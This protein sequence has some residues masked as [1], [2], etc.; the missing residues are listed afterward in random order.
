MFITYDNNSKKIQKNSHIPVFCDRYFEDD[1]K[2]CKKFYEDLNDEESCVKECPYGFSCVKTEKRI[3]TCLLIKSHINYNKVKKNLAAYNEKISDYTVYTELNIRQIID[4]IEKLSVLNDIYAQTVHDIKNANKSMMDLSEAIETNDEIQRILNLNPDL[5]SLVE[6]YG[7]IKYRLDYHDWVI[8][9]KN[10][11][12]SRC[13]SINVHKIITKLSYQLKYGAKK[14]NI[15][16]RKEGASY[17][18]LNQRVALF[19]GFFLLIENAIKYSPCDRE[20]IIKMRDIDINSTEVIIENQC[21]IIEKDEIPKLKQT[22]FRA[23]SAMSSVAGRGLGLK[24]ADNI[25]SDAKSQLDI[26]YTLAESSSY[27]TFSASVV[28]KDL[29]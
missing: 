19:L 2:K 18:N 7:L 8:S 12:N 29:K 26:S 15:E 1:S 22:H 10:P 23:K 25:F 3:Y 9:A 5:F 4:E 21:G 27:G 13:C 16:I 14:K 11:F 24:L 17:N 28:L 20:I 6:G